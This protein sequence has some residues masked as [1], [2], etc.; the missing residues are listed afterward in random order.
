MKDISF[1]TLLLAGAVSFGAAWAGPTAAQ[2]AGAGASQLQEIVVTA[3]RREENL[4]TTPVAITAVNAAALEAHGVVNLAKISEFTPNMYT[5]KVSGSLGTAGNYIRG[6]GYGDLALGQDAPIGIYIDGVYN[7]RN[8]V[9]LMQLVEPDRVEV[10]RGPQGTLFGRNTTGGAVSITTHTPTNEFSGMVKASY[11]T[12][13]EKGV[14]ARIDSGELGSTGLKF[15]VAAQHRQQNGELNNLREPS[16][17]DPNAYKSDAFWFKAVGNW[18]RLSATLSSDYS[19]MSGAPNYLQIV[20][21][22]AATL[23]FI[24]SSPSFGGGAYTVTPNPQFTVPNLATL[25]LQTVWAQGTALTLN[26]EVN[27]H[28]S[29]KSIS[30]LRAYKRNDPSPN[31]PADLRGNTGTVANPVIT[32]FPGL[33]VLDIRQSRQSQY[34]EELQALGDVG[35]FNYVAGFFYFHEKGYE[36]GRTRLPAAIGAF[37][38][39]IALNFTSVLDYSMVNKSVAGF[40]QV[41]YRP[42]FLDKKLELTGGIRWTKDTKNLNQKST[43]VRLSSLVTKNWSFL[44]SAN[45]QWTDDLM[46]YAK[47]S[48]GYRA[49]GFN[50]RATAA[51]NPIYQPEKMKSWEAG[52]KTELLDRRVRLN[53]AAFYNKYRDLQVAQFSP[54]STTGAGGSAAVNANATYKGFELETQAVV[55]EALTFEGSVGYLDAKYKKFPTALVGGAVSA[56][57]LPINNSAGVAVGQDCAAI[58]DVTNS[59]KWTYSLGASYVL[60][61]TSYGL[62]TA[63]ATYSHKTAIEWG[64]LNLPSTPFKAQVAGKAYGLLGARLTLSEIPL[65]GAARA[66]LAIFGDNLTNEKY[67]LQGIDFGFMAGQTFG[68]RRTVGVEG[69]VEF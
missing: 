62:W 39:N 69:K 26:Y 29:L 48:T 23:G 24:A 22:N 63:R 2:T 28:L 40:G 16:R 36:Y 50:V 34:T 38:P 61:R 9:A 5:Y 55:T 30:S 10:L 3:R 32:S 47:F 14:Q 53:G 45:Y 58:A 25:Q 12:F 59:P 46:T 6:V 41:N 54:P 1:R 66:Q 43:V 49:G 33:Y 11:G 52:F 68:L 37:G 19:E 57:C 56:G 4:Q 7:G 21:A 18:D 31:G 35:D 17:R 27:D 44:G 15:S 20:A 64:T 51:A 8:N 67:V 65:S 42:S 13:G 60:P